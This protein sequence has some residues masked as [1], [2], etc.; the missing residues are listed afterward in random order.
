[1]QIERFVVQW[2]LLITLCSNAPLLD[3][4]GV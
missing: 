3:L 2:K 1:M 4:L